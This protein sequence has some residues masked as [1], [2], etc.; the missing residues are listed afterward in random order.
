MLA[1]ARLACIHTIHKSG[2][3]S[4]PAGLLCDFSDV[5]LRGSRCKGVR[6]L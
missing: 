2:S 6:S 5:K 4:V 1:T 3:V